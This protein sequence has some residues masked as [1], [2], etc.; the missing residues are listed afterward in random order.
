MSSRRLTL[1][2]TEES[3]VGFHKGTLLSLSAESEPEPD[4]DQDEGEEERPSPIAVDP[5]VAI[6]NVVL[7]HNEQRLISARKLALNLSLGQ[8]GSSASGQP[9][10][11]IDDTANGLDLITGLLAQHLP[12]VF[13]YRGEGGNSTR[14][15]DARVASTASQ[16]SSGVG[17][18]S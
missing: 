15:A 8:P 16:R 3:L 2:R 1:I 17:E 9:R 18:R 7:L 12:N 4:Q 10:V 5:Y 11:N 6:P 13:H 14:S